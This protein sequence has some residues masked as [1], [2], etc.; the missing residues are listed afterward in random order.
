MVI[1]TFMTDT[2]KLRAEIEMGDVKVIK[3]FVEDK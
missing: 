2:T 3:Q 1:T